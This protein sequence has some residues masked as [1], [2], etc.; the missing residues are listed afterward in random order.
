MERKLY[1]S[2]S[3][4]N[5]FLKCADSKPKNMITITD[6]RKI[7]KSYLIYSFERGDA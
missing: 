7:V 2:R 3:N 4:G 5:C 1:N 6:V